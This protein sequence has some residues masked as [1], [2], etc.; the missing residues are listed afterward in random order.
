M[1]SS[2][3][4]RTRVCWMRVTRMSVQSGDGVEAARIPGVAAADAA[5]REPRAAQRAVHAQ[6]L[7]AVVRARR[8]EAALA[9]EHEG[10]KRQEEGIQANTIR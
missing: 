2:G 5:Q 4:S 3:A 9:P 10:S 6:R 7:F 8:V 1:N